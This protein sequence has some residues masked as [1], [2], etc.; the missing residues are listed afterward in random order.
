MTAA[1]GG[2]ALLHRFLEL[3]LLQVNRLVETDPFTGE[4]LRRL[5]GDA[6][7]NIHIQLDQAD[8][9]L[10]LRLENTGPLLR[11]LPETTAENADIRVQGSLPALVALALAEEKSAALAAGEVRI[12]GDVRLAQQLGEL[13]DAFEPDAGA[14]LAPFIGNPL[15]GLAQSLLGELRDAVQEN[16]PG[17]RDQ[18]AQ[19]LT[20][21]LQLLPSRAEFD[22]FSEE[23]FNLQ[24][25]LERLAMRLA[26]LQT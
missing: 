13:A 24:A 25:Q 2:R 17:L 9:P 10:Q 26:R 3:G 5:A 15:A 8:A 14:L 4:A 20:E 18:A 1:A 7:R 12:T 19:T 16:A 11:L 6:G 22:G 23:L 21:R